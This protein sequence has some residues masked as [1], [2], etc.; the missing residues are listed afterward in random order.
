MI[1]LYKQSCVR[2][3]LD[4]LHN[5]ERIW[6]KRKTGPEIR[7]CGR[8]V[9]Q[10]DRHSWLNV[11]CLNRFVRTNYCIMLPSVIR[12]IRRLSTCWSIWLAFFPL[13]SGNQ[14]P[15]LRME[16]FTFLVFHWHYWCSRPVY[17]FVDVV[18]EES[19]INPNSG[20]FLC[21]WSD[22]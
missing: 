17:N 14:R 21:G 18:T 13:I 15:L 20:A 4:E 7:N 19:N 22:R 10:T 9:Y 16:V 12:W 2:L 1:F 6:V 8:H 3:I 11:N 5:N